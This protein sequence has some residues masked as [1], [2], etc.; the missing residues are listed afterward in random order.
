MHFLA[1]EG[2]TV[3]VEY[4]VLTALVVAVVGVAVYGLFNTLKQKVTEVN[5]S[6]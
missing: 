2:G 5:S 6:L 3:T 4:L 1:D